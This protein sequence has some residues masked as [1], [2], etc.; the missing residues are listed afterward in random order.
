MQVD[1]INPC[2]S[3]PSITCHGRHFYLKLYEQRSHLHSCFRVSFPKS[4]TSS[5]YHP[6]L[7][8][9]QSPEA[10]MEFKMQQCI[11]NTSCPS[12]SSAAHTPLP[13][14]SSLHIIC[15]TAEPPSH[16]ATGLRKHCHRLLLTR[17]IVFPLPSS[18]GFLVEI[19]ATQSW[20]SKDR[21][22]PVPQE[23]PTYRTH[24]ISP[25]GVVL[26]SRIYSEQLLLLWLT[27]GQS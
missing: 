18:L 2:C 19:A 23:T 8:E 3:R 26:Y 27:H 4:A 1:N 11:S 10:M 25:L 9:A 15:F 17:I 6:P 14:R 13:F 22:L 20:R 5:V 24:K 16:V 21:H 7:P 12:S